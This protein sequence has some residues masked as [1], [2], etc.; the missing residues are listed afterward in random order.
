MMADLKA[1]ER[2]QRPRSAFDVFVTG[3]M[4]ALTEALRRGRAFRDVDDLVIL[5]RRCDAFSAALNDRLEHNRE[6]TDE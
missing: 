3:G 2:P 4:E 5:Q 1:V 6:K